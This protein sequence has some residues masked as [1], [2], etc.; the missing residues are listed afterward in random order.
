MPALMLT[1]AAAGRTS[2]AAVAAT[3][4]Q[5]SEMLAQVSAAAARA[6]RQLS[7]PR[8]CE[9]TA[10][11][12]SAVPAV[13]ADSTRNDT[14]LA[15][16]EQPLPT[17]IAAAA[18]AHPQSLPWSSS[19]G[20]AT[21]CADMAVGGV[22]AKVRLSSTALSGCAQTR[23]TL[24]QCTRCTWEAV[25]LTLVCPACCC[26]CAG[27]F[28][29]LE[30]CGCGEPVCLACCSQ[31]TLAPGPQQAPSSEAPS[32]HRDTLA[33]VVCEDSSAA[34]TVDNWALR[35]QPL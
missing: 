18:A 17:P 35:A 30:H 15:A 29:G 33:L 28:F 24:A 31:Q 6:A 16:H 25:T 21:S 2:T 12:G 7:R 23:L 34:D 32:I 1:Q 4:L 10:Q 3:P 13:A 19:S 20:A 9:S 27:P 26:P 11:C 22:P 5:M 8:T 14:A